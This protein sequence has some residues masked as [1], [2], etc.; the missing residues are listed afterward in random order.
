MEKYVDGF[1][2]PIARDRLDQY[3][4]MAETAA[5]V[6]KAH[7]ALDYYE[8]VGDDLDKE[9][10]TSFLQAAGCGPDETVILSW[11]VYPSHA[12]RDRINAAVMAD[13]R[14]AAS[15]QS[16]MPFEVKRMAYGGFSPLVVA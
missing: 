10:M 14:I 16:E 3:K 5:V 7:G 15:M 6:W 11:I 12:E 8:C 2:I 4:A 9:G 13:P 1:L